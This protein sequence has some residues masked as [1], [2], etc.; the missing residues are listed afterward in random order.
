VGEDI[1]LDVALIGFENGGSM[2]TVQ[3]LSDSTVSEYS[4]HELFHAR[5]GLD[6]VSLDKADIDSIGRVV[7]FLI[8]LKVEKVD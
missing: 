8:S 5:R 6:Q 2:K 1:G 7:N 4:A 3:S